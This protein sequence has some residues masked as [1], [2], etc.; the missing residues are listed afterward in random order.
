GLVGTAGT[1]AAGVLAQDVA[2]YRA[3]SAQVDVKDIARLCRAP[4]G[5][6]QADT[7]FGPKH[8]AV[9]IN[10]ELVVVA[11][12][13]PHAGRVAGPALH[14]AV[15]AQADGASAVGPRALRKYPVGPA[16][17]GQDGAPVLQMH[18]AA[19]ARAASMSRR[20]R[21]DTRFITAQSTTAADGLRKN[22]E[23]IGPRSGDASLRGDADGTAIA[24]AAAFSGGHQP[25]VGAEPQVQR[26]VAGNT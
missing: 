2:A 9:F 20:A 10:V 25:A 3:V 16:A 21:V 1:R 26:A 17:A 6:A 5:V 4:A 19:A 14:C 18:A 23:G 12:V 8:L 11:V 7:A 15:Q 24:V 13:D 22:A